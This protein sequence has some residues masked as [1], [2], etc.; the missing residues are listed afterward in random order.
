[1]WAI[2]LHKSAT[3]TNVESRKHEIH[4]LA[5]NV[6]AKVLSCGIHDE[7]HS[8]Q[9]PSPRRRLGFQL[10]GEHVRRATLLGLVTRAQVNPLGI[11]AICSHALDGHDRHGTEHLLGLRRARED[12]RR[13]L[14]W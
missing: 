12:N 9:H 11:D 4:T 13:R 3:Y 14:T 1:M 5:I 6:E 7:R 2:D 10:G 8:C